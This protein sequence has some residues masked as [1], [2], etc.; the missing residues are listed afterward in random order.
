M[1]RLGLRLQ[2]LYDYIHRNQAYIVNYDERKHKTYT[3]QWLNP[4]LIH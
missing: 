4:T 2:G 3:S 1:K